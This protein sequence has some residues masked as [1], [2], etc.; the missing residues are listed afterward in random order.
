[1]DHRIMK[2]GKDHWNHLRSSS[3]TLT[4]PIMLSATSPCRNTSGDGDFATSLGSQ[5]HQVQLLAVHSTIQT[6]WLRAVLQFSLSSISSG[7]CP[8]PWAA[9]SMPT[10]LWERTF[11]CKQATVALKQIWNGLFLCVCTL[12]AG[13]EQCTFVQICQWR[14]NCVLPALTLKSGFVCQNY[15]SLFIAQSTF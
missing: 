8:L 6:L 4:H 5:D 9:C 12:S 7:L 3:P 15:R 1:M 10:T 2:V 11:P 13:E 14:V